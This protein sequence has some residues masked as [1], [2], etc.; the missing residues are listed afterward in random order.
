MTRE[1]VDCHIHPIVDPAEDFCWYRRTGDFA[2][3]IEELRRLGITR[4]CGA[5][6]SKTPAKSFA[7]VRALNDAGLALRDRFPDFYDPGVTIHTRYPRESIAELERC[8]DREGARWVGE[9]VGYITGYANDYATADALSIFR[10]VARRGVTVNIH[11]GDFK[12]IDALCA[13]IPALRVVAAHL[14][15][16][17]AALTEVLALMAKYPNLYYDLSG[18]S[19]VTRYGIV[20][21]AI[22]AVGAD[23]FLFG[24]DY[25]INSP[26]ACLG[27]I[28]YERLSDSELDA[29]LAGNYRRL[30][31][32][33]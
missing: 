8:L 13:A 29:V 21:Y 2:A 31:A 4:A 3:Q 33:A 9:L 28:L 18:S 10:E 27:G 24:S 22:D 26:G 16:D 5:I 15:S 1:I 7:D 32:P 12:V 11:C 25:P 6:V 19:S 20:R 17:R 14:P 23:R 30:T